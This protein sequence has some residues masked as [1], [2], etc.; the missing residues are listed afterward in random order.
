MHT[1]ELF[2]KEVLD[3]NAVKVG[4]VSDIDFN[5]KSGVLNQIIVQTGLFKQFRIDVNQIDKIG[6]KLVLNI[7]KYDLE[8]KK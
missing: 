2:D 5:L 8:Q 6:D 3:V 7:T 1:K 4:K